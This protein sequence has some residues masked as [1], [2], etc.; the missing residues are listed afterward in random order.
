MTHKIGFIGGGNMASSLIGGLVAEHSNA[1][2]SIWVFEPN[3]E[4]AKQLV[5]QFDILTQHVIA[6]S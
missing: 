5:D 1:G 2:E 6:P 4:R 3:T